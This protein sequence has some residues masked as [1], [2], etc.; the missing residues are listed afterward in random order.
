[1]INNTSFAAGATA[2]YI[3]KNEPKCEKRKSK[4]KET[5]STEINVGLL[6]PVKIPKRSGSS[7]KLSK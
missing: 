7:F 6:L 4:K 3:H 1:M 2:K 5:I